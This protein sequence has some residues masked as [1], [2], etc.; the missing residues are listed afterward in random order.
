MVYDMKFRITNSFHA[1]NNDDRKWKHL[2]ITVNSKKTDLIV[3]VT[4]KQP[5]PNDRQLQVNE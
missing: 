5:C 4:S 1:T 2:D 3:Q